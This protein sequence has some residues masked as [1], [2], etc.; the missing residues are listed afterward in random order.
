MPV[1]SLCMIVRNEETVLGR[2]LDSV[3]DL[4]DEIII[5]DTGSTDATKAAAAL[6]EAKV[7]DFPWQEDFSAARNYAVSQ[8]V[9][10]Y[11]M[12]LDADDVIEGENRQKLQKILENP[13]ADMVYLPYFLSFDGEGLPQMMSVRER[14]FRRS[15][16]YQFEG[17]VHEAVVPHGTIRY[18]DAAISHRKQKVDDVSRNLRIYQQKLS[19]GEV[20]S[21]REQYYYGRELCDHGA[22][23][24]ALPILER[25]LEEGKGWTADC[26]GA[27]LLCGSCYRQ[28]KRPSAALESLFR[29]FQYDVPWPEACC[30]IGNILMEQ[31][32]YKEAVFWFQLAMEQGKKPHVG[33]RMQACCDYIPL[34]QLCVCYDRMGDISTAAAYNELAGSVRPNDTAVAHNRRYFLSKGIQ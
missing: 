6:Y 26:I 14:I 32:K 16:N 29:T 23:R 21:P 4:V 11:W 10:D 25:F 20:F 9:G 15:G 2:C 31:E 19:R 27:C 12:W 13:G 28:L 8:A 3:A 18:G 22:F 5:V 1:I 17:A 34:L 33:F 24:A 30:D 7:Y